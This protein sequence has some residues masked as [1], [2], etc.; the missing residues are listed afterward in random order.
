MLLFLESRARRRNRIPTGAKAVAKSRAGR[1]AGDAGR[2]GLWLT[3]SLGE[4]LL[5]ARLAA[6]CAQPEALRAWYEPGA[7][8]L[9]AADAMAVGVTAL[10]D[11]RGDD[12]DEEEAEEEEEAQQQQ[13]QQQQQPEFTW[14]LL[15][16]VRALDAQEFCVSAH[17]APHG[18]AAPAAAEP[19]AGPPPAAG[20]F[21]WLSSFS[22]PGLGQRAPRPLQ[23]RTGSGAAAAPKRRAGARERRRGCGAAGRQGRR[24]QRR[25]GCGGGGEGGGEEEDDSDAALS[26]LSTLDDAISP[27]WWAGGGGAFH[28]AMRGAAAAAEAGGSGEGQ[29]SAPAG[30][31]A[32]AEERKL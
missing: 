9:R 23:V 14:E 19:D 25:D 13:Q 24:Q 8:L 16:A 2:L 26:P 28:Q 27:E 31:A 7:L 3:T 15:Q 5:G 11:G 21:A 29:T 22:F 10:E 17:P 20:P 4:R 32:A 18:G 6:V 1:R 12:Y 30:A